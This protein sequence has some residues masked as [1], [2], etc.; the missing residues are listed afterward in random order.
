MPVISPGPDEAAA[1]ALAPP[2]L[3]AGCGAP[4][5]DRFY[6]LA[7]ER[8]WHT[9]CLRCCH[10]KQ[11]LDSELTCFAR[12]GNIYCKEDYYRLFAVKRCARCQQGI[13]ASELVMR[14]RDLVYHLHCFTCAWCNAA[15]AQGDHFG[16]RDNLVYCRTHFELLAEGCQ[17]GLPPPPPPPLLQDDDGGGNGGTAG[18]CSPPLA[19]G[20][21]YAPP[22]GPYGVR[23]GRP[24]KR[25]PGEL[26]EGPPHLGL[27]DLA[28]LDSN[29]SSMLQQQQQQQQRTKRMRTSFKHHQLRTMKSYFAINQ[30]PDAKDLKQLAQKTGLS[31]R[32]LQVWFQNARAKWRRNNLRQQEQ[33]TTSLPAS[34]PG[35][36]SSFSEPSP[37]APLDYSNAQTTLVVTASQES[38]G[39]FQELF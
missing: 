20:A 12:D 4:I 17:P 39:S 2:K 33:P 22:Q 15:L 27:Q 9:H 32:V 1:Q 8:Q 37:G 30:N 31:K 14:A 34:S 7:V 6:L 11:Q 26:P 25:K 5:A 38:L 10:C 13:F 24:R 16:L 35:G 3:C 36:T 29:G 28:G 19:P 21:P 18:A 23:K